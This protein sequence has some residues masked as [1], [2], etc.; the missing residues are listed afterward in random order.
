[1]DNYGVKSAFFV[2]E[3]FENLL[4]K[5]NLQLAMKLIFCFPSFT[6]QTS[7]LY[8]EAGF[9]VWYI[10]FFPFETIPDNII[11]PERDV[12]NLITF[13]YLKDYTRLISHLNTTHLWHKP[14]RIILMSGFEKY[15]GID[16]DTYDPIF[17]ALIATTLLNACSVASKKLNVVTYAVIT[18]EKLKNHEIRLN[19]LRNLYFQNMYFYLKYDDMFKIIS[20]LEIE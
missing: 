7:I 16:E 1:M 3:D 6:L 10:S 11:I 18:C 20:S 19:I 14:P 12:L 9:N 13:I 8:A 17:G 4:F 15:S 5:V 2:G